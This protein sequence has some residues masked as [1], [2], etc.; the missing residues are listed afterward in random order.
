MTTR[1]LLLASTVGCAVFASQAAYADVKFVSVA[2]AAEAYTEAWNGITDNPKSDF[3]S[4]TAQA[5]KLAKAMTGIDASAIASSSSG[6][7]NRNASAADTER[8]TVKLAS[9][10]D[11]DL[12]FGGYVYAS[13]T[14]KAGPEATAGAGGSL[15]FAGYEFRTT[16]P[17]LLSI[18]YTTQ[19][20]FDA[21]NAYEL[22]VLRGKNRPVATEYF[23]DANASDSIFLDL[24][25]GFY[26]VA[27]YLYQPDDVAAGVGQAIAGSYSGDFHVTLSAVPEA[28]TWVMIGAG[29]GA[30]G[31]FSAARRRKAGASA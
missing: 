20:D 9:K 27:V 16:S 29:F 19:S 3:K 17:E 8:A 24:T 5:N 15:S 28:S 7:N 14:S 13:V 1:P 23:I 31:A 4:K 11:A 10:F 6:G 18:D 12:D 30:L 22:V 2:A 26:T 21:D 25:K